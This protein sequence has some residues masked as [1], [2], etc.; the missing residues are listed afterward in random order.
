MKKSISVLLFMITLF[1]NVKAKNITDTVYT[2]Y[3]AARNKYV[4][5]G[6]ELEY[7]S[8]KL[9]ESSSGMYSGGTYESR[10]LNKKEREKLELL[11]NAALADTI[12]QTDKNIKPNSA[13]EISIDIRK[14]SFI[15]KAKSAINISI[16]NYLKQAIKNLGK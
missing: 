6:N 7:I 15:L 14:T 3:D 2:Y 5:K 11:F 4:L 16:N 10:E 13:I 9:N 12:A 8:V 1:T